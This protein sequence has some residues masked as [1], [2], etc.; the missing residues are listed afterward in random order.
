MSALLVTYE[1]KNKE[2]DYSTFQSMLR[3]YPW[4]RVNE[5]TVLLQSTDSPADF[6]DGIWPWVDQHDLVMISKLD[7]NYAGILPDD[8]Q[9]WI[10]VHMTSEEPVA[11]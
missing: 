8:V 4:V 7:R 5:N 2:M 9:A 11:A 3:S 1:L 6:F 10:K